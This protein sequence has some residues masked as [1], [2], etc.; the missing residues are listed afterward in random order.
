MLRFNPVFLFLKSIYNVFQYILC[1]GSTLNLLSL[2]FY[3][4]YFNTSYVTVQLP[5]ILEYRGL[6]KYFNTSYVTV[7]LKKCIKTQNGREEF[8]YILCYGS[9]I[10]AASMPEV[11]I[12]FQYILCYGS[13]YYKNENESKKQNFNTSYVTVQHQSLLHIIYLVRISIHP[14]LRFNTSLVKI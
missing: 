8:Q 6:S 9:T 12:T 7:Q 2:F 14:M 3:H 1:Y 5:Y 4:L 10:M 11:K 13:T